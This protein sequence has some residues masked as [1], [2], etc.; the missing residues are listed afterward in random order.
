[1]PPRWT[2]FLLLAA[3]AVGFCAQSWEHNVRGMVAG[4]LGTTFAIVGLLV[5]SKAENHRCY[6]R[7]YADGRADERSDAQGWGCRRG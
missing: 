3:G 1:M 6:L 7:G 5:R 4:G 2:L